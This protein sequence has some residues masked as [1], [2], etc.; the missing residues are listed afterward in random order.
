MEMSNNETLKRSF[1]DYISCI[2]G[3]NLNKAM[4]ELY[5]AENDNQYSF[6]F[7][8]LPD[9]CIEYIRDLD[10]ELVVKK[11]EKRNDY[12][13]T[14]FNILDAYEKFFIERGLKDRYLQTYCRIY[15]CFCLFL[16]RWEDKLEINNIAWIRDKWLHICAQSV[17][18]R[19]IGYLFQTNKIDPNSQEINAGY[20]IIDML[21]DKTDKN[22]LKAEFQKL[23]QIP[24][25]KSFGDWFLR[26][27]DLI[28]AYKIISQI[29]RFSRMFSG[30]LNKV[31]RSNWSLITM[32]LLPSLLIVVLLL[33]S[34]SVDFVKSANGFLNDFPICKNPNLEFF[35]KEAV[36]YNNPI[37]LILL[38]IYIGLPFFI[39]LAI[40]NIMWLKIIAPR[41]LAAIMLGFIVLGAAEEMWRYA[42]KINA[43]TALVIFLL[44]NLVSYAY[45]NIEI[46]NAKISKNPRRQAGAIWALGF[47]ESLIASLILSDLASQYFVFIENHRPLCG[48]FGIIYPQVVL[49]YS[50]L[51]LLIG[52]FVQ[53]I[54]EDK[55]ITHPL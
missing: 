6:D 55:P 9:K 38:G 1:K 20:Q 39:I 41:L 45:L 52:I 4:G 21:F 33:T 49:I 8:D 28:A 51:A 26:C 5:E 15:Y 14:L 34:P 11:K 35:N 25:L 3:E 12:P 16:T 18:D 2:S 47:F 7:V 46:T 37:S 23:D 31:Y 29:G 19:N 13:K 53:V 48:I 43:W 17:L 54:W 50:A 42:A 36:V 44:S 22:V 24:R 10:E 30:I 32:F 27:Y 40:I